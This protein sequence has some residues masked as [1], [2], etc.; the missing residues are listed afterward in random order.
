MSIKN[1]YSYTI[2]SCRIA[3]I[4]QAIA[5]NFTPLLF[6]TFTREFG[7]TL[8]QISILLT[9]TFVI[10]LAVDLLATEFLDKIGYRTCAI[11]SHI[12]A[13]LGFIMLGIL[14]YSMPDPFVGIM[15]S[16][17][18]FSCGSGM[19]EIVIS[20][21][22]ESCPTKNKA[23][24][25]GIMHS[26]Y[27]WGT[28]LVILVSTVFFF[29]F[30]IENW[31]F[32]AMLWA[33]IPLCNMLVFFFAPINKMPESDKNGGGLRVLE[34]LKNKCIWIFMLVMACGGACEL[35]MAQWASAFFEKSLAIP[36][37]IGDL[38]GPFMFAI[39]MGIGRVVYANMVKKIDLLS[40]II[41]C[42]ALCA[43]AYAVSA[44]CPIPAVA[45]SGCAAVGFSVGVFWPGILSYSSKRFP[46]G[47]G[48]M[49][50]LLAFA[51]DIGC[52]LGPTAVGFVSEL[53]GENLNAGLL[54]VT[55]FPIML[56]FSA[57]V[58]KK[59]K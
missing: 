21:I 59:I 20:P 35:A 1:N 27:C 51:G 54:F 55:I 2:R 44:I 30:G 57:L 58:C 45:L 18:F 25:M 29:L 26:F 23:A 34:L 12:L 16:A 50:A 56:V 49:F 42:A 8:S 11:F 22:L 46:L 10:Q 9:T 3:Y 24:E 38:A 31:R 36:K 40:Y 14:P 4:I 52:T 15:I 6:L 5:V 48:S 32:I 7:L 37:A 39:T 33:L 13:A 47:G 19:I 28:A 17:F 41:F 53:M 43:V